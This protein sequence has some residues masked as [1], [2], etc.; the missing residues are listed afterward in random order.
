MRTWFSSLAGG[1]A[2]AV[3]LI[4]CFAPDSDD[5]VHTL[6]SHLPVD[7]PVFV[8]VPHPQP[9]LAELARITDLDALSP[10]AWSRQ[11]LDP[12]QPIAFARL[13]TEAPIWL[14]SLALRDADIAVTGLDDLLDDMPLMH[15]TLI[16][17]HHALVLMA[18]ST[19]DADTWDATWK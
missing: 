1:L 2:L 6:G 19:I 16:E 18:P 15:H 13:P 8:V 7:T 5:V 17:G 12:T 4:A 3:G 11:G 14:V 10:Q 9:V